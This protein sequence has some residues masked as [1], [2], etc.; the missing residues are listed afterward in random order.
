MLSTPD[1]KHPLLY[2]CTF[3]PKHQT[4]AAVFLYFQPQTSN[5]RGCTSVLSTPNNKHPLLY[6]EPQT[7]NTRCCTLNHR[8]QTPAV[9]L[10]IPDIEHPLLYFQPQ[11]PNIHYA[12]CL[13]DG[14]EWTTESKI[15]Y[16]VISLR[17]LHATRRVTLMPHR[18][19][20]VH[21]DLHWG[22]DAAG[23][24]DTYTPCADSEA[25]GGYSFHKRCS[26]RGNIDG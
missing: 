14:H 15:F 9:V 7:S 12:Y 16:F 17:S 19:W 22:N 11:T 3:N 21:R 2:F 24:R 10:S 8:H 18:L 6:F 20:A 1:I 13:I 5:T 23:T 26:S 4:P 25:R